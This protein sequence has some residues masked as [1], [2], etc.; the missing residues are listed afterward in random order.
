MYLARQ[1]SMFNSFQSIFSM[2]RRDIGESAYRDAVAEAGPGQTKITDGWKV[3]GLDRET[4]ERIFE[5]T[6]EL[7]F[8]S[9]KELWE[10]EKRDERMAKAAEEERL[11]QDLRD[12]I[13]KDG[14]L[15]Q[16]GDEVDEDMKITDEDLKRG[17]DYEDDDDSPVIPGAKECGNCGYTLFIAEGREGKFFSSGFTC[18]ECGAGRDQFKHVD[19][20]V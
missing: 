18:P 10:K 2:L 12:S 8:L 9:R 16:P 11:R 19:V 6:K 1:C 14:N 7:G 13:D 5:E 15:I 17:D 3:V 4:A 20:D